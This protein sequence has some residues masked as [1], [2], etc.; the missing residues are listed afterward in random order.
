MLNYRTLIAS[1]KYEILAEQQTKSG[2][3][4]PPLLEFV[5]V[6]CIVGEASH[7]QSPHR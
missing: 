2:S 1:L 4:F 3:C 5:R 6:Q 7:D